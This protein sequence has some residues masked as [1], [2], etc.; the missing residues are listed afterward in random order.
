MYIRAMRRPILPALVLAACGG[1]SAA[2]PPVTHITPPLPSEPTSEEVSFQADDGVAI[3][4]SYYPP[5]NATERCAV[6]V[7]QLSSTRAEY[8]PLI[9][10]IAHAMHVVAIDMRGHGASTRGADGATITWKAFET[11]DWEKVEG[12]V[13]KAMAF[14]A[15]KGAGDACVLVGSS[16]GSSA[17]LRYAG[18]HPDKARALVLLSPGVAYRGVK[19]PDAARASRAPVLVVHS[20]ENG[21]ADAAGA[22][23][24][25]WRD[26]TPPVAVE[27]IADPGDAH[28]M[29]IV[30]GDPAILERVATFVLESRP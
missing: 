10:R 24:G 9:E 6:L 4:G 12:D 21:A 16:I 28:G 3:T 27:I 30:S 19:T 18:A 11:A 22:L 2:P 14:L 1:S 20:Q 5:A 17:V 23:A 26:A 15:G 7:H 13:G 8:R 29:R 25:I